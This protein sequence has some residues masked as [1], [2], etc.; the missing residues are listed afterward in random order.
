LTQV[1][2]DAA[3]PAAVLLLDAATPVAVLVQQAYVY[4]LRVVDPLMHTPVV[5]KAKIPLVL[6]PA[7]EPLADATLAAPTPDAVL[8][9]QAYVNLLR[10]VERQGAQPKAKIPLVL[11]P[12]AEPQ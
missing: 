8:E 5:P 3:E 4:L 12:A 1:A 7:A 11:L 10:M 9:Q 6:L 2:H